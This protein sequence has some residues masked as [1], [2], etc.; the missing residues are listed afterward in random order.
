MLTDRADREAS[1]RHLAEL[2]RANH[3]A[4]PDQGTTHLRADLHGIRLRWELHTEFVT[5]TFTCVLDKSVP[6]SAQANLA[7]RSLPQ[8]WLARLPGELLG[9]T[10]LWLL[11]P[12]E[13][14]RAVTK[15]LLR[16]EALLG[17]TSAGGVANVYTDFS[18][19]SEGCCRMVVF[20]ADAAPRQLGRLVQQLIEVDTYR[21]AGLLGLPASRDA[22]AL[23]GDAERELASLADAIRSAADDD[24][25]RLLDRLTKLAGQVEGEYAATH[26]RLSA[27]AAY[28]ELV[29]QRLKALGETPIDALQTLADFIERRLSPAR[30]TCAWAAHRQE[31]LSQ[32]VS[33]MSNLLRTRVE[34]G[35]QRASQD[36]LM[37]MNR[38]QALQ[39]RLQATVEG[40][41]VAA[42]TYYVVGL[43]GYVAKGA[44]A[45]G[46]GLA[47]EVVTAAAIPVVALT[48]WSFLRRLHRRFFNVAP[49]L[50]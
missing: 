2:L 43:V 6:P 4:T 49:S 37:A 5:W 10:H 1:R 38:R 8:E 19:D 35:Q 34:V 25:V 20:V 33:R 41:S 17:S 48:A 14:E 3:L 13:C 28:F 12:A 29:D 50:E 42:I 15:T 9:A 45:L 36:V 46:M 18:L 24:E 31:A 21:M 30:A 22:G 44:K 7:L 39:L 27:S 47:A 23:L 26:S 40:L 32:R 11:P 16:E